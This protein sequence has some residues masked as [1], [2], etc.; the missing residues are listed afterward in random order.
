M[1]VNDQD[2][3]LAD[4]RAGPRAK[5]FRPR[6]QLAAPSTRTWLENTP[7]VLDSRIPHPSPRAV[8][9]EDAE[10]DWPSSANASHPCRSVVS[11]APQVGRIGSHAE[12]LARQKPLP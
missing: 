6:G 12:I 5:P 11:A 1:T 2:T 10:T 4:A 3:T 8:G 9:L 7:G